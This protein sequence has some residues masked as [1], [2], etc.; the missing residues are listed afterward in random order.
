[1]IYRLSNQTGKPRLVLNLPPS[2]PFVLAD[3]QAIQSILLHL[4]D[5]ALKYA[6]EGEV[7]IEAM[8][9]DNDVLIQVIDSGPGIPEA[10]RERVFE[11]FY[12]LDTSDS[13]P[14]YGRGLGL[15]LA[16]RFLDLMR[17]GIQIKDAQGQGAIVEFWLPKK[18]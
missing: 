2:L 17:G 8:D 6:P 15:N 16:K 11:M 3:E 13:R 10:E 7:I 18:A 4:V 14:V 5:N 1:V 12:R 9:R